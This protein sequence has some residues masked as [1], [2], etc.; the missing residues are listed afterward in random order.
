MARFCT[1]CGTPNKDEAGFCIGC[2]MQMAEQLLAAAAEQVRHEAAAIAAPATARPAESGESGVRGGG[3]DTPDASKAQSLAEIKA[4]IEAEDRAR[5]AALAAAQI[6]LTVRDAA[7]RAKAAR[8]AR[9]SGAARMAAEADSPDAGS[10]SY[11]WD[12]SAR[13]DGFLPRGAAALA[14]V[15]AL[16]VGIVWWGQQRSAQ[17][18]ARV[19]S[20]PDGGGAASAARSA[21]VPVR[22]VQ[23]GAKAATPMLEHAAR[24]KPS[25]AAIADKPASVQAGR[26]TPASALA[27]ASP[28]GVGAPQAEPTAQARVVHRL[29][30]KAQPQTF[31]PVPAAQIKAAPRSQASRPLPTRAQATD[32]GST[33]ATAVQALRQALAACQGKDNFFTRQ[34]CIQEAR[35]KYCGGPSGA[36]PLWGKIS[37]CPSATAQHASP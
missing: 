11:S 20:A 27:R 26:G 13:K 3:L 23:A 22:E 35:W 36:E 8:A 10:P 21:P 2:G 14:A 5:A 32:A 28:A 15:V 16:A 17:N 4:R 34:L 30:A 7:N 6:P 18:M 1:Q 31:A 12:K 25:H 9:R 33:Q 24:S 37:E 29:G 19:A